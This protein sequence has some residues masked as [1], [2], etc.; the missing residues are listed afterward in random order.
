MHQII[1]YPV[2]NGDTSQIIL[3][4][5]KRILFDFR[6]LKKTENGE[7]PEINL[8]DRLKDELKKADKKSF[9]VVAFSP[10]RDPLSGTLVT[11]ETYFASRSR[12]ILSASFFNCRIS[13]FATVH[14]RFR[15]MPK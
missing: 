13:F 8:K 3:E 7:G 15:S 10:F 5:G 1:V 11:S 14:V 12:L 2:G 9:D 4:N 6:H